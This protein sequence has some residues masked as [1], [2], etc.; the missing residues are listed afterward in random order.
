M[1]I[2]ERKE[3]DKLEMRRQIIEAA[4]EMFTEE[5]YEKTSIRNIAEKIEYSPAT[6]YLYYKDKDELLYEVQRQ[7]FE[8][9]YEIFLKEASA[10]D[11]L[12]RLAQICKSYVHFGIN[13]P[14]FYD[15]MFIIKAPMNVIE[16]KEL[17]TNGSPCFNYLAECLN[18]CIEKKL[19]K[20]DNLSIASLSVW[21]MGHGL[22]SLYV[23]CR[24]KVMQMTDDQ[25]GEAI[26]T[27]IEEF[28]RL[29]TK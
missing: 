1:G 11:P 28:L 16:E 5:G 13:N 17:W 22:I 29:I 2:A 4:M 6:I 27:S 10:K 8:R 20:Y 19:I 23:R 14:D 7:A 9:M 15:L 26:D 21:A 24:F 18:E 25:S 12:E 3:R